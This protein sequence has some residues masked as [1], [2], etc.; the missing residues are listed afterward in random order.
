MVGGV[1]AKVDEDVDLVVANRLRERVVG[2][3]E[4]QANGVGA[5]VDPLC[6]RQDPTRFVIEMQLNGIAIVRT[7]R[8]SSSMPIGVS[9]SNMP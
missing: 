1:P 5:G 3:P 2:E 9:R 7:N 6:A 4:R 8:D